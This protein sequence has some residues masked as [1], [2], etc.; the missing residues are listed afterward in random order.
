MRKRRKNDDDD[1]DEVPEL[2]KE[3]KTETAAEELETAIHSQQSFKCG[4]LIV[5]S[6]T[7][8]PFVNEFVSL[9]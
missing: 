8:N 3:E 5:T 4:F 6:P 2:R 1:E 9:R 7:V